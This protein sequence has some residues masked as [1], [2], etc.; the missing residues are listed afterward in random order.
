MPR[1]THITALPYVYFTPD[2]LTVEYYPEN[3]IIIF[4]KHVFT[5]FIRHPLMSIFTPSRTVH[6][7]IAVSLTHG[8]SH[9]D[10]SLT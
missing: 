9:H 4:P 1:P 8:P 3:R 2:Y 7:D 5:L 10:V 6:I